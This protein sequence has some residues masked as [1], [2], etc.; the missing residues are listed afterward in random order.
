MKHK[1]RCILAGLAVTGLAVSMVWA[2]NQ[3]V[4]YTPKPGTGTGCI[5]GYVGYAKM[6]NSAGSIWITPPPN[7]TY[8]TLTDGSS[9][10]SN[11][12]SIATVTCATNLTSTQCESNSITFKASSNSKYQLVVYVK[13]SPPT[14]GESLNLLVSWQ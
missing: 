3:M 2:D 10:G 11:Y 9:F 12:V 6:T 1:I 8:G 4:P 13:Q 14:N 7:T 5:G